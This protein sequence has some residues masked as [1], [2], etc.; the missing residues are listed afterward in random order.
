MSFIFGGVPPT[1]A[2]LSRRYKRQIQRSIRELDKE[3]AKLTADEKKLM[4]EVKQASHNNMKMSMQK[5]QAVVRLRRM[6][7]KF[8]LM[9][10][11]FQGIESRIHGVNST[12]ALQKIMASAAKMM[13]SFNKLTGGKNL[14][15]TMND[16]ERQNAMMV[17]H[18][19]MV[20]DQLE[21]IFEEETDEDESSDVV[22]QVLEEAGVNLPS[23]MTT[24]TFEARL[25][26]L[27]PSTSK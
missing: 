23:S 15:G 22:M 6:L 3:A 4:Q 8:S 20:D 19:E 18:G 1:T 10:S 13:G 12:E 14:V 2:E 21:S 16:L 26:K 5:A 7:N 25:E 24:T 17:I 27:K 11:H 9:K